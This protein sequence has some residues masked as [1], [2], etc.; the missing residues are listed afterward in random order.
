[1][2]DRYVFEAR[3]IRRMKREPFTFV[4]STEDLDIG[5]FANCVRFLPVSMRDVGHEL[6]EMFNHDNGELST[7]AFFVTRGP[8]VSASTLQSKKSFMQGLRAQPRSFSIEGTSEPAWFGQLLDSQLRASVGGVMDH[9]FASPEKTSFECKE[10]QDVVVRGTTDLT[11]DCSPVELKTVRS[12]TSL[13][14]W[15]LK[16]F[17]NQV[18]AYQAFRWVDA[19]LILVSRETHT[20][21]VLHVLAENIERAESEWRDWGRHPDVRFELDRFLNPTPRQKSPN[22]VNPIK[23]VHS[24]HIVECDNFFSILDEDLNVEY[25]PEHKLKR[26][27]KHKKKSKTKRVAALSES[28]GSSFDGPGNHEIPKAVTVCSTKPAVPNDKA[29]TLSKKEL[30][31]KQDAEFEATIEAFRHLLQQVCSNKG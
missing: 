16:Y 8:Y 27:K 10:L 29:K 26:A 11:R 22:L 9:G 4:Q 23:C 20:F 5:P 15:K 31:R 30:K 14:P 28:F 24:K 7:R 19:F 21:T 17:L 13:E 1:M 25:G 6:E 12:F 2:G 18:A 3:Q